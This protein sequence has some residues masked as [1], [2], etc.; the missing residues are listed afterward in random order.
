MIARPDLT[1]LHD[2]ADVAATLAFHHVPANRLMAVVESIRGELI[3]LRLGNT[4]TAPLSQ[5]VA[6]QQLLVATD[7][8]RKRFEELASAV[9]NLG[10]WVT[11]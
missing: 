3:G 6:D 5:L 9:R 4:D 11:P 1:P 7:E 8:A 2:A 10:M